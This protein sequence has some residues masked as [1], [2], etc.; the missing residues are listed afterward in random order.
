MLAPRDTRG[1]AAIEFAVIVPVMIT[2][3]LGVVDMSKAMILNQEVYNA[4]HTIP[5]LASIEAV[6][7]DKTTT[8]TVAQVQQSLS[9]IYAEMPWVRSGIEVGKRS[10]TMSSVV[11][12][13]SIVT[14]VQ[15]A[16]LNCLF[17]PHV[18][19]S[20][21]YT[22]ANSAGFTNVVR[23]CG[24]LKQ[25]APTAGV[26]SDL[27]SLRTANVN[28]PDPILVVDVHYQYTP[29][30]FKFVTG[31][32]DFWASGYWPVRSVSPSVLPAFQYTTYDLTNQ[33]AGAGKCA[34]Y[35]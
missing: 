5:L 27:T 22:D 12:T 14:C 32:V 34:G 19:W 16:N 31:A 26:A 2:M 9:A 29:L 35:D 28:N 3:V 30:F 4:A 33:A 10:V 24:T 23:S 11:F 17:T 18:A 25:T 20:V 6:Q 13:P 7:P 15:T 1:S 21:A 8:L